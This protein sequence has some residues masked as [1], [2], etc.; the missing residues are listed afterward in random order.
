VKL[1]IEV[2]GRRWHQDADGNRKLDDHYRDAQLRSAGW[3]V[4]RF[5]VDELARDMEGCLD[6]IER[7]LR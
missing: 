1:D 5:W 3:K 7:E 2:D 4:V 6:R